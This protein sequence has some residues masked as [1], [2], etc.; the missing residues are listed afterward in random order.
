MTRHETPTHIA[1]ILAKHAPAKVS[2]LLDPATGSGV[3]VRPFLLRNPLTKAICIDIDPSSVRSVRG[4]F[5]P[6]RNVSVINGDFL[7]WSKRHPAEQFDCVVMNPPFAARMQ[8]CVG[9]RIHPNIGGASESLLV[10]KEIA[11]VYAGI[12]HLRDRGRLI[13]ILPASVICSD[14]GSWLRAELTRTGF[15]RVVHELPLHTFAG[16][17]AKTFIL[18]Y[19]RGAPQ[20]NVSLRNHRLRNPDELIVSRDT[21]VKYP[22]FDFGYHEAAL[23]Y[24]RL[25]RIG[26]LGWVRLKDIADC[27]RG[28]VDSPIRDPGILHTKNFEKFRPVNKESCG[29]LR[30]ARTGDIVVKRVARDCAS[31]W[32]LYL[33]R[34]CAQ[35]SDCVL[36]IRLRGGREALPALFALRVLLASTKGAPLVERGTAAS[37]LTVDSVSDIYIPSRLCEIYKA[38]F[39]EFREAIRKGK[40]QK[41]A[42]IEARVR[43]YLARRTSTTVL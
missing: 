42:T 11:F 26:E 7:Q 12:S 19:E 30:P 35:C 2:S 13:A 4:D 16:V 14:S 20:S 36:V 9:M 6:Y 24:E 17:E 10:A 5:K 27:W 41:A 39:E 18:I 23:W 37:Y 25:R 43:S 8:D 15:V 22:R 31:S 40:L 3:L 21:L 33:R 29:W 32:M 34:R 1:S 38:S 28:E